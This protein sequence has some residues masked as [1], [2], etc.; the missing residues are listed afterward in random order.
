MNKLN[1]Q[2]ISKMKFTKSLKLKIP[3]DFEDFFFLES[4]SLK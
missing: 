3:R 2:L 1:I 4:L